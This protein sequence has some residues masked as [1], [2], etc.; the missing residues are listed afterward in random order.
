MGNTD[1]GVYQAK[2]IDPACERRFSTLQAL[3]FM[4]LMYGT[5]RAGHTANPIYDRNFNPRANPVGWH[6]CPGK[7]L[8]Y[9]GE[10]NSVC[11]CLTRCVI[12]NVNDLGSVQVLRVSLVVGG[13]GPQ[14]NGFKRLQP[15]VSCIDNS[16]PHISCPVATDIRH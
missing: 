8:K 6:R 3:E 10:R 12:S 16:V 15:S 14:S 5:D 4:F 9:H 2:W 11:T 7:N 1:L 13:C